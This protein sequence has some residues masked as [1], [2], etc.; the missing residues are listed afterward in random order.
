[1]AIDRAKGRVYLPQQ[2]LA[3]FGLSEAVID[4]G[5]RDA[6][7]PAMMRAQ[8]ARARRMLESGAPLAHRLPGRIGWELRLVIQGGLR[9]LERIDQV[10]GDVFARRPRLRMPDWLRMSVRALAM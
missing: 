5:G 7:W 2:E 10:D 8:T 9:I 3:R 1:V 4:A 6:R